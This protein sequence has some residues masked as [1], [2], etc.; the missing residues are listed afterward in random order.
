MALIKLEILKREPYESDRS[1]GEVGPYERIDATAHY[2]VDP[3]HAANQTIVDL[4]RA[5]RGA[6][7]KVHFSG[8]LTI[9]MPSDPNRGNRAL[10]MQVPNRGNRIVTRFNM[11]TQ[12]MQPDDRID[13]GDGFLFARGWTVAWCGWQWDV[14]R[15]SARIGFNPPLVP[16]EQC[17]PPSQMQLRIQPDADV[18]E[19]PLTD[20]P[21]GLIG[22]HQPIAPADIDDPQARLLVRDHPYSELSIIPR[23]QWCFAQDQ[24]GKPV[25]DEHHVWLHG[26]FKAGR[27][28]DIL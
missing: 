6:D 25:P 19:L 2:A 7:G 11:T 4:D 28:Y 15:P 13:P 3:M 22:R 10:L 16:A 18:S 27:I 1:F 26:G 8:D 24:G 21:V 20:Q 17:T 9:L 5:E 23:H 12:L 14:P